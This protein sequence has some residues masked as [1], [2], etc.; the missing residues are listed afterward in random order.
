MSILKAFVGHSFTGDDEEVV[1]VILEYF[2]QIQE[3]GIGFSWE[4]AKPA[5]PKVLAEKVLTFIEDKNLFIGICTRKERVT[6][7]ENLKSK[8]ICPGDLCAKKDSLSWKTS[9]WIIQE[10]GLAIGKGMDV[11]LLVE[12][13]LRAPGGLQGNLEYIEFS[14]HAP[15][16]S[17]GKILEMIRALLPKA[18]PMQEA[19]SDMPK[20]AE[21]EKGEEKAEGDEWTNPKP[22][23][24]RRNY[25]YALMHM[26]AMEDKDGEKRIFD[27]YLQTEEGKLEDSIDSWTAAREYNHIWLGKDGSLGRLE[28]LAKEKPGNSDVLNYLAE[29]YQ[30]FDEEEKAAVTFVKSASEEKD[31]TRELLRMG[32]A[33]KA[34]AR[35]KNNSELNKLILEIKEKSKLLNDG[36]I[37][38]LELLSDIA[39][40]QNDKTSYL[41][42]LERL[43]DLKP[44]DHDSR[45]NLAYGHSNED[46]EAL[47]LFHY[48][49]IPHQNRG[50]MT[51]NNVGVSYS[52]L[53]LDGKSIES[54]RV[55]EEKDE[56]LAMDNIARKLLSAG[57]Y[58]EAQEQ[59]DKAKKLKDYNKNVDD[60][61]FKLKKKKEEE[62]KKAKDLLDALKPVHEFFVQY[63]RAAAKE[64]IT[65]IKGSW[66]TS[67]C[68]LSV[69]IKGNKFNAHGTYKV[70]SG[71]LAMALRGGITSDPELC[72][73]EVVYE[74][75]IT[76]YAINATLRRG[77]VGKAPKASTLLSNGEDSKPVLMFLSDDINTI[78]VYQESAT[79]ESL[80]FH[81]IKRVD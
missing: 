15:E 60:T 12:E 44:D 56:T 18:K 5:E 7:D 1:K 31:K 28:A 53:G 65:D 46:R 9:D 66:R 20:S 73:Y 21:K 32:E 10:I 24:H 72:K 49:K 11:I 55:A 39:D 70:P 23:W 43:L 26:V 47:A 61:T 75:L 17:F 35:A 48:L 8:W 33:A 51:W 2:N 38:L 50:A 64:N 13:G 30:A 59:C 45:F 16:K 52:E 80:K 63:G 58:N 29:S 42:F 69:E 25:E 41:T 79:Y 71:G 37:T 19:A 4:H 54:Y 3:M 36:E 27:A 14:R 76:G 62:V 78:K 77:E 67:Q 6:T 40:I 68:E 57:F 34:Y 81:E 74:G 22:E